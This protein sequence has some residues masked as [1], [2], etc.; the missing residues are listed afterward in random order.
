MKFLIIPP[1]LAQGRITE[2][3]LGQCSL[4]NYIYEIHLTPSFFLSFY[5]FLSVSLPS[6]LS[7]NWRCNKGVWGQ[8][9]FKVRPHVCLT[10][11]FSPR[12]MCKPT[13]QCL[14]FQS[15]IFCLAHKNHK[16]KTVVCTSNNL[17]HT[18]HLFCNNFLSVIYGCG[19]S[20]APCF[21]ALLSQLCSMS[22][23]QP[24]KPEGTPWVNQRQS[25][26]NTPSGRGPAKGAKAS[27]ERE[28]ADVRGEKNSE[29]GSQSEKM[30]K[31]TQNNNNKKM[32]FGVKEKIHFIGRKS[33]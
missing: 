5:L 10:L 19:E 23:C 20:A 15:P 2:C 7:S 6:S 22:L 17:T 25:S 27:R 8:W 33:V 3:H 12:H 28:M 11:M 18:A 14:P 16:S 29:D 32:F 4:W 13:D 21:L 30:K 24:V 1:P 26:A 9:F 31:D